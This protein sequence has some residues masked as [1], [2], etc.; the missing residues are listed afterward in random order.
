MTSTRGNRKVHLK[1]LW[2]IRCALRPHSSKC[3]PTTSKR[4]KIPL[5]KLASTQTFVSRR[6]LK[7]PI[8]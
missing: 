4:R 8:D 2:D 3:I 1:E 5:T 6:F 7:Y